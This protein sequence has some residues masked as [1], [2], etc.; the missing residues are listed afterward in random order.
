MTEIPPRTIEA[1]ISTAATD[2]QSEQALR[3]EDDTMDKAKRGRSIS[4]KS[5]KQEHGQERIARQGKSSENTNWRNDGP[6]KQT[7]EKEAEKEKKNLQDREKKRCSAKR[8][9]DPN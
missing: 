4:P 1:Q 7:Q 6:K 9:I 8:Q 3:D 5:K 2:N